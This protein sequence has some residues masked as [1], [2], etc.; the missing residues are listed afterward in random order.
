MKD[1]TMKVIIDC[2]LW[3]FAGC[4]LCVTAYMICSTIMAGRKRKK[5]EA[6]KVQRFFVSARV[7]KG[8]ADE[9]GIQYAFGKAE[10][11]E[12]NRIREAID[13]QSHR[14]LYTCE[15]DFPVSQRSLEW[16]KYS[17]FEVSQ[18]DCKTQVSWEN[19]ET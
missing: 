16:L 13:S 17:G 3:G 10:C 7:S 11:D 18:A 15:L 14:G 12:R 9:H 8:E 6:E 4:M 2:L 19:A 1:E 5:R